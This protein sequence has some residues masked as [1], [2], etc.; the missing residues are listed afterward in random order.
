MH[1]WANGWMAARTN[2]RYTFY[3][4]MYMGD[5]GTSEMYL[6]LDSRRD[7]VQITNAFA[8]S[9]HVDAFFM[10]L[11]T[12]REGWGK[13]RKCIRLQLNLGHD[14]GESIGG[15]PP[16]RENMVVRKRMVTQDGMQD[17][18]MSSCLRRS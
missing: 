16:Q 6:I 14:V 18:W 11:T 7:N 1:A 8:S 9:S 10:R 3:L 13:Y 5:A 12:R 2:L 4:H 15:K 17:L